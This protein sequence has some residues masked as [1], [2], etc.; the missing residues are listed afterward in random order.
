MELK[1]LD[2]EG[3]GFRGIKEGSKMSGWVTS[4]WEGHLLR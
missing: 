1:G 3:E 4:G 2:V